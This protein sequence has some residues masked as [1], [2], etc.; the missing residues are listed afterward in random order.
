M[1]I[2]LLYQ[3]LD[4]ISIHILHYVKVKRVYRSRRLKEYLVFVYY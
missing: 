4:G 3:H 2:S 1:A